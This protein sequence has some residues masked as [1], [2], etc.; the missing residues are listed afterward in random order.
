MISAKRIDHN[1][2][3]ISVVNAA[4]VSMD[5]QVDEFLLADTPEAEARKRATG[6]GPDDGLVS[7]L[8]RNRH[9]TPFCH[10]RFRLKISPPS[11]DDLV[12]WLE[13]LGN[14]ERRAGCVVEWTQGSWQVEHSLFGWLRNPPPLKNP[15]SVFRT[16][17]SKCPHSAKAL[18]CGRA[19]SE[20]V[21]LIP[22]KFQTFLVE[23]PIAIARQ[24][25]RS[26]VGVVYNEVSRRYV[27]GPPQFHIVKQWRSKVK[28]VKQGSGS[29]LP[30][31]LQEQCRNWAGT[32]AE[33][34]RQA[35][36]ALLELGASP[37]QA[38]FVLP[39]S[40]MTKI[41]MT[42]T[43]QALDRIIPLREDSHAQSEIRDLAAALRE[44]RL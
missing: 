21:E 44:E 16:I 36:T 39:G 29:D 28:N 1:S 27:S 14:E 19:P 22:A 15:V 4:R 25:M 38:R 6:M 17:A 5:K 33:H 26:N 35:Y 42:A 40:L 12:G 7:Y 24:L 20:E 2:D 8:A 10:Q 30:Q 18:G 31:E 37:E 3:D 11:G 23:I 9:F 43:E 34:C 13:Y 32:S 41:W